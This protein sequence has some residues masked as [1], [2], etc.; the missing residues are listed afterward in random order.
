MINSVNAT[1][2]AQPAYQTQQQQHTQTHKN[3]QNENEPQDT[4]VLSKKTTEG[5]QAADKD[6]DGDN[7]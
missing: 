2:Q 7:H 6:H 3:N 4:V 5:S 1:P